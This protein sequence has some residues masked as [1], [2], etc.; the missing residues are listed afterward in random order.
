M[1]D[2]SAS[3]GAVPHEAGHDLRG[4][5]RGAYPQWGEPRASGGFSAHYAA[6]HRQPDGR[7]QMPVILWL[8]GVP[9][10]VVV[11]L[12]LLHVI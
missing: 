5:G 7:N 10:I 1:S 11:L 2:A 9:L 12:M 6:S 3:G 4:R 8:L